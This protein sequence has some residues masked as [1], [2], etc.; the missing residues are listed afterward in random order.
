MKIKIT[1]NSGD[2]HEFEISCCYYEPK[3]KNLSF[4]EKGATEAITINMGVIKR[5]Y[6]NEQ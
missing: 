6:I 2:S 4:L 3:L 5:F 1:L